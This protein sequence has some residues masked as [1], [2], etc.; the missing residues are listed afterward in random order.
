MQQEGWCCSV[1][2]AHTNKDTTNRFFLWHRKKILEINSTVY[3]LKMFFIGQQCCCLWLKP[4]KKTNIARVLSS[5]NNCRMD[6]VVSAFL[7]KPNLA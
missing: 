3:V 1:L 6:K 4:S 5:K 2:Y 7:I